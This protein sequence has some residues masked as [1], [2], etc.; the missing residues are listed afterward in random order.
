MDGVLGAPTM[1]LEWEAAEGVCAKRE[2]AMSLSRV[3]RSRRRRALLVAGLVA[4]GALAGCKTEGLVGELVE[5]ATTPCP[6]GAR[7][8]VSKD[9][10]TP[11]LKKLTEKWCQIEDESGEPVRHGPYGEWYESGAKAESGQYR[12]GLRDDTW[13]RWYPSGKVDAIIEYANGKPVSFVAWHE[14]GQRWEEGGFVDGFKQ[15][16]WRR[17]YGNG[18]KELEASYEHGIL[19]HHYT[20][21]HDNGQ[22]QEEGDYAKGAREGWWSAWYSNGQKRS[23]ILFHEGRADDWY[24]AWHENGTQSHLALFHDGKPEG[25]YTIWHDNG[26]KAEEGTYHDGVLDGRITAWDRDGNVWL[27]TDYKG[28]LQVEGSM[29]DPAKASAPVEPSRSVMQ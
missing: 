11:G 28:G 8:V 16:V 15:G 27:K 2:A 6:L 12:R 19:A 4:T 3:A 13:T 29:S 20:I 17:W 10:G 23:D 14:N 7:Y 25:T 24:K 9:S 22:R 1:G 26:Q 18:Q 21:W 5:Y